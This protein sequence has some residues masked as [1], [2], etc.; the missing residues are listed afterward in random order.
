MNAIRRPLAA[1]LGAALAALVAASPAP[2]LDVTIASPSDDLWHYPFNF[3]YGFRPTA[4]VFGAV[5][6]VFND[7]DAILLLGFET[8]A[9]VLTGLPEEAYV[10]RSA[11]VTLSHTD[12]ASWIPDTTVDDVST[13]V[14]PETDSDPGRPIELY[15]I[16]FTTFDPLTWTETTGPYIGAAPPGPPFNG[17]PDLPRD[18]YPLA[19]DGVSHVENSVLDGVT[20]D[21]WA[22]GVPDPSYVPDAMTA[23]FDVVFDL[24]T[25]DSGIASYLAGNLAS[26]RVLLSVTTL[27]EVPEQSPP[28]PFPSFVTK[29]G[30]G[31]NPGAHPGV[32]E[33]DVYIEPEALLEVRTA[34]WQAEIDAARDA[35]PEINQN[36]SARKKLEVASAKCAAALTFLGGATDVDRKA[37]SKAL[38]MLKSAGAL[39]AK[40]ADKWPELVPG[41][42]VPDDLLD[43]MRTLAVEEIDRVECADS[44]CTKKRDKATT[45]LGLGD[46]R[47]S[48]GKV[49]SAAAKYRAAFNLVRP[50]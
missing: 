8:D 25:E 45:L 34:A 11:R 21:P 47:A 23:P 1:S 18:P 44:K 26:G 12:T 19:R 4:S 6:T 39:V 16:G 46:T 41:F 5:G 42:A 24:D 30:I 33:L 10:V 35:I 9:D 13:Y 27:L 38:A 49:A 3:T 29:E 14:A 7:R 48:Q 37:E 31:S 32:L 43:A 17:I 40:V 28:G 2:A 15:G 50:F 20:P 22:I 36:N